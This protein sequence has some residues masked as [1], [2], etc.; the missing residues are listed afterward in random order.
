MGLKARLLTVSTV[1]IVACGSGYGCAA[2]QSDTDQC[3][4]QMMEDYRAG[5][6]R[7]AGS[8][9]VEAAQFRISA[10]AELAGKQAECVARHGPASDE[11]ND[12][13]MEFILEI[14]SQS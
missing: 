9:A 1:L 12:K 7:T 14:R 10:Q 13:Q 5:I 3:I 6:A 2:T 8:S 11:M 4:D